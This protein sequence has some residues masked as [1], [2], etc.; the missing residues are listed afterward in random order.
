MHHTHFGDHVA[1]AHKELRLLES[2]VILNLPIKR[3]LRG[4]AFPSFILFPLYDKKVGMTE[5]PS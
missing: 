5:D 4:H 3:G 1:V 2:L